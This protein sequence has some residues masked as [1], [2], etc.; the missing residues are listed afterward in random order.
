MS[1]GWS[2]ARKLRRAVDS[3]QR[4]IGIELMA[5]CRALELRAPVSPSPATAAVV[6]KVR[7]SVPGVG[8]DRF[9]APEM[10]AVAEIV[11]SGVLTHVATSVIGSL[12]PEHAPHNSPAGS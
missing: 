7:E 10:A 1:M 6:T 9:L 12:T 11:R 5:A 3:V 2:A 8:S 4:V